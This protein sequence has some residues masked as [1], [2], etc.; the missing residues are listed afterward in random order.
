MRPVQEGPVDPSIV[1]RVKSHAER[2]SAVPPSSPGLLIVVL[3]G[4]GKLVV[5][6]QSNIRPVDPH[7]EGVRRHDDRAP[8]REEILL[9]PGPLLG[10][11]T[12]VVCLGTNPVSSQRGPDAFHPGSS[13]GVDESGPA[14]LR[15]EPS[16]R[17]I[18][19]D[20]FP[21]PPDRP[22]EVWPIKASHD[23]HRTP[24]S[25]RGLDVAP[26]SGRGSRGQRH[27]RRSEKGAG[28]SQLAIG[29]TEVVTP[30]GN[31]VRLIHG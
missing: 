12:G 2:G 10:R 17:A 5:D 11:E 19:L 14:N 18:L 26:D 4:S 27:D 23:S 8:I 31:T 1:S 15:E 24:H 7:S 22:L 3:D 28:L 16:N 30:H 13:G 20:P 6:N 9:D 21:N 25:E 29:R